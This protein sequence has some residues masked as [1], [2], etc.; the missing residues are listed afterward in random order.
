MIVLSPTM[1]CW[2]GLSGC[3]TDSSIFFA[4]FYVTGRRHI[5]IYKW[6]VLC[7]FVI[8]KALVRNSTLMSVCWAQNCDILN[9]ELQ[10]NNGSKW[11]LYPSKVDYVLSLGYLSPK[12]LNLEHHLSRYLNEMY[13]FKNWH[14]TLLSSTNVLESGC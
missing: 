2:D 12:L 1:A 4:K 9:N 7:T 13:K 11:I 14:V 5:A 10:H 8:E 3:L 6:L